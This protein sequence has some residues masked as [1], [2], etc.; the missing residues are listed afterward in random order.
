MTRPTLWFSLAGGVAILGYG[1]S[2]LFAQPPDWV[3][4]ILGLL[5]VAFSISGISRSGAKKTGSDE[6]DKS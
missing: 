2:R 6:R 4:M 5:I 1:I 3:P